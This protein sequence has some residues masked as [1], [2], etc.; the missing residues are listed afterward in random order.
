M[1]G[2]RHNFKPSP[3]TI[4]KIVLSNKSRIYTR[5]Y[6]DEV[7]SKRGR[8]VYVFETNSLGQRTQ[9]VLINTYSSII[10]L[11]KAYNIASH[12]N[13]IYKYISQ[14]KLFDSSPYI[15]GSR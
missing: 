6:R 3:E 12:H 1:R 11:K 7:S 10:R 2:P 5:A 14:G 8:T 15:E 4:A 9:E 13:T